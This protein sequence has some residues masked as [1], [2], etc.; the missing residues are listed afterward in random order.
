MLDQPLLQILLLLGAAFPLVWTCQ[1]LKIP[2]VFGYLL[3]GVLL[4]PYT[5]GPVIEGHHLRP[6]AEYGIV[7]L[8][9]TVGLGFSPVQFRAL[10]RTVVGLGMA[11][12]LLT[13]LLIALLGWLAGL[14]PSSALAI[15]AIA[16]QS[17]TAIIGRM[18]EERGEDQRR[19]G[20]L[21]LAVSVFQDITAVPLV[22]LIPL[23]GGMADQGAVAGALGWSLLQAGLA[24]ALVYAAGRWL[25]HP[26]FRTLALPGSNEPFD[27]AVLFVALAAAWLTDTLG[28]SLAFGGFLVG[29]MLGETEFRH[30]IEAA[31]RPLRDLLLGLFFIGIGMLFDLSVIP[32]IWSQVIAATAALLLL[33]TLVVVSSARLMGVDPLRSW[34][35][36]LIL[37]LG[38]EFGFA[39]LALAVDS[40]LLGGQSEQVA[41]LAVLV[42]M[43]IGPLLIRHNGEI[44]HWLTRGKPASVQVNHPQPK[45]PPYPERLVILCGYGRVGHTIATLLQARSVPFVA[46]DLDLK[47]I[48]QGHRQGHPVFYGN[49]TDI[50]LFAAFQPERAA[51]IVVTLDQAETAWRTVSMLHRRYPQVPIISRARDLAQAAR[52]RAAGATHV[53]PELIE[54]SLQL[55]AAALRLVGVSTEEVEQLIQMIRNGDDRWVSEP[56]TPDQ[57]RV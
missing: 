33:K 41:L 6:F 27:L 36:A 16:A 48:E 37:A 43:F 29:M 49:I 24:I 34:R 13:A 39:L 40:G 53:Y 35:I 55:G 9:F 45:P 46:F 56:P 10:H 18:L 32:Q 54:S 52:L 57:P 23:L 44:A 14:A 25:L 1:R 8:L 5:P 12:V 28:L 7:F 31:I 38:G 19:H 22:V 47:R 4:G 26:L 42:S 51:L 21:A 2:S 15:G 3:A 11:Q 30:Q 50:S 17:S 20:R